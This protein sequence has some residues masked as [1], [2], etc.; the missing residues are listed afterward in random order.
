M[1]KSSDAV[2]SGGKFTDVSEEHT[3][4]ILFLPTICLAYS[5]TLQ[6]EAVRSSE[7][8]ANF[9]WTTRRHI[10]DDSTLRGHR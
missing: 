1:R 2:K 10:T 9:Q 7:T 6:M 5:S 8:L 4:S 3:T